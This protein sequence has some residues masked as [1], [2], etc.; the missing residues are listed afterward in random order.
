MIRAL[1]AIALLAFAIVAGP[2]SWA[3]W[4]NRR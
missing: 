3:G 4:D 2:A 1:A